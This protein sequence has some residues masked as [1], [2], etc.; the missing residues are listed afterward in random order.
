MDRDES[1]FAQASKQML[2]SGNFIDI[3]FG[4]V[5]RYK[6]PVGIYWL[7]SATTQVATSL[8]LS[9]P[10]NETNGP[11]Q[12]WTYRLASFLGG[13]AAVWLCFWL[14]RAFLPPGPSLIGASLLAGTLLLTAEATIATTD[15]VLLAT[16]LGGQGVLL[17][18]YLASRQSALSSI[19]PPLALAGWA[20]LGIGILIKGPVTPALILC[21]ALLLSLLDR[22]FKWLAQ[23]RPWRGLALLLVIVLPWIIAIWVQSDGAFFKQSLG[24]DFASKLASGQESH[25]APP[26]YYLALVSLSLWPATLFL[27]PAL[28]LGWARRHEPAIRFL[29]IWAVLVW[30]IIELIPTKLPHYI[31]PAYPALILLVSLWVQ[32]LK[33][34]TFTRRDKILAVLGMAQFALGLLALA[35]A[36]SIVAML[37]ANGPNIYLVIGMVL[38]AS[39]GLLA[40]LRAYHRDGRGA[41]I[42]SLGAAL[43][44]YSCLTIG[45]VPL[46][47]TLWVSPR[48]SQLIDLQRQPNDPPI[49]LSGYQEPSLVFLLGT[50]TRLPNNGAAAATI[51][52]RDGGLALV[53]SRERTAFLK[54][55]AESGVE[56]T[57]LGKLEGL[58]YSRGQQVELQ[59]YRISP[60]PFD[61]IPPAE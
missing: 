32:N 19:S 46:L 14:A 18:A 6:K 10:G 44:L 12:I 27:L 13:L 4:D 33:L 16:I 29:L 7:Q 48:A 11:H 2:E 3:R 40:I 51:A 57:S 22:D 53:E 43:I 20:A 24:D 49:I 23:T 47:Q 39:C 30:L 31:L 5:P 17:R 35:A 34:Q 25:G 52:L 38:G 36:P 45:T 59:L 60:Q 28:G 41:V 8:G 26:G 54:A 56:P 42:W 61:F 21:T 9:D 50:Q 55:L 58:N 37:Y 1:R 15:A